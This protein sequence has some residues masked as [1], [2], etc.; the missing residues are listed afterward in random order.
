MQVHDPALVARLHA[1]AESSGDIEMA[2]AVASADAGEDGI[3]GPHL[4]AHLAKAPLSDYEPSYGV[5][6]QG[7]PLPP[8]TTA[9]LQALQSELDAAQQWLQASV[10]NR[11]ANLLRAVISS[12]SKATA[13]ADAGS[14]TAPPVSKDTETVPQT[15]HDVSGAAPSSAA[16]FPSAD[17]KSQDGDEKDIVSV[18]ASAVRLVRSASDDD[19]GLPWVVAVPSVIDD[20]VE[21]E[22]NSLM[23]ASSTLRHRSRAPPAA[24]IVSAFPLLQT[25]QLPPLN[26]DDAGQGSETAA[27]QAAAAARKA[28]GTLA[29]ASARAKAHLQVRRGGRLATCVRTRCILHRLPSYRDIVHPP[30][31]RSLALQLRA[32]AFPEGMEPSGNEA[33]SAMYNGRGA[34]LPAMPAKHPCVDPHAFKF[35]AAT[36]GSLRTASPHLSMSAAGWWTGVCA[37]RRLEKYYAGELSP[38]ASLATRVRTQPPICRPAPL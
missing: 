16:A 5:L 10:S 20:E 30:L 35:D 25:V 15:M 32:G 37:A 38:F 24:E 22:Y 6:F 19:I 3:D 9:L 18:A 17:T 21:Q 28:F 14:A 2:N 13:A 34:R 33:V 7:R 27:G 36:D 31:P 26:P 12:T 29:P 8:E 11:T 4:L 23:E 1:E